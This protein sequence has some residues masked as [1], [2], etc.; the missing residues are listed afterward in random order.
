VGF[1]ALGLGRA[2]HGTVPC[3]WGEVVVDADGAPL[4]ARAGIDLRAVDTGIARRDAD[5]CGPRFLDVDRQPTMTWS[6]ERFTPTGDGGWTAEGMLSVRGTRAPLT[7]TGRVE[8]ADPAGGW[9]RVRATAE[10]DRTAVGIRAP[11]LLVG[12]RVGISIDAW[13]VCR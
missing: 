1:T 5:L 12:R 13:L 2:V 4:R 8:S 6:A 7:V 10:I 3:S 11:A 9:V